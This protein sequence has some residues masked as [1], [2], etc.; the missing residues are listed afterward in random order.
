MD[1]SR[2]GKPS[3]TAVENHQRMDRE[4]HNSGDLNSIE[5]ILKSEHIP[6]I[7]PVII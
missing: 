6:L 1:D 3:Q 5:N 2:S 7:F 4:H